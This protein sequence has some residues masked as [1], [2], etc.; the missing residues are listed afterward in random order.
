MGLG[1][2]LVE[3]IR[4]RNSRSGSRQEFRWC[5]LQCSPKFLANSATIFGDT[6]AAMLAEILGEFAT[7]FGDTN[8]RKHAEILGDTT[9]Q[10]YQ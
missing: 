3:S 4:Q 10:M 9:S 5:R 6:T 2:I 7:I 1:G 8:C